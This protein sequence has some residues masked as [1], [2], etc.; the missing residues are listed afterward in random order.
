MAPLLG[1][2]RVLVKLGLDALNTRQRPGLSGLVKECRIRGPITPGVISFKLAPKINALGRVGDPRVGMQLLLSHSFTEARRLA[3]H[4]MGVNRERQEI[5]RGVYAHACE[6][7]GAMAERPAL[8]LV[9]RGWHPGVIGSI[10]TRIAF[11]TRRPT[12]VLSQHVTPEFSG[13]ARSSRNYNVLGVLEAC[14]DLLER[15]GGHPSAAGLSLHEAN[16]AAFTRFFNAAAERDAANGGV[17]AVTA[18]SVRIET[19][20]EAAALTPQFLAEVALM[21]PF[22]YGNPEPVVGVRGLVLG[23]P[24][25]VNQR[26]L[27]FSLSCSE[28]PEVQATAW[29]RSTWDVQASARY[30]IAFMPQVTI[31][32]DGPRPHLRVL[33]LMR[34]DAA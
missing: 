12:V 2:N 20:I 16:L 3:R 30:D 26:H 19:W 18:D 33:D 9:G 8:I 24:A 32:P 25:V 21:S 27:R 22:G 1:E 5:E 7:M 13:S 23:N 31:G 4:L 28:G 15:F 14:H 6:Q 34:A 29:D 17:C 11:E 10:A